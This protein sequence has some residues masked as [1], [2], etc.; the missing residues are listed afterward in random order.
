MTTVQ[1]FAFNASIAAELRDRLVAVDDQGRSIVFEAPSKFPPSEHQQAIF[2][3]IATQT[4]SLIARARA[5]SG[6]TTTILMGL[7]FIPGIRGARDVSAK[8]FHAVGLGAILKKLGLPGDQVKADGGK[9]RRIAK[10]NLIE[11]DYDMYADF[12]V[13]LVALAKG[14]GIGPLVPDEMGAWYEL[15]SHH[16]LF[17]DDDE[18]TEERGIEIARKLL[19]R[20]N[21]H[22]LTG[23]IDF[24]DMLYLPLLWRL[25]L[26][27]NDWVIVDEA[28]DTSPVRRAIAKLALKPGGRLIAVG[29]DKQA[30]YGF[31]GASHDAMDLIKREFRCAELPLTVS[32]RCPRSVA[33]RV[34]PLVP[35]FSVP[36]T[37]IQGEDVQMTLSEAIKVLGP[38]DAI[39]C[40]Q[41][42]PL[43]G[44][45]FALIA[46]GTGCHVL[47]KE[48]GQ[49]LVGLIKRQKARGIENL[50]EKLD[51]FGAREIAK[52]I[53][54]GE[55]GKAEA[56]SDRIACIKTVIDS[57]PEN[58]R[59][60]PA[61][62]LKIEG[63]FSDSNGV[64][65]LA[66]I[67]KV[68][69]KEYRRVAILRPD[70]MPSKWAR[71]DHQYQ[72]EL[73]LQYVAWTRTL[74][75]LIELTTDKFVEEKKPEVVRWDA[76]LAREAEDKDALDG[77]VEEFER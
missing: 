21:A 71:Q 69:G 16:D 51:A 28:Q 62:I 3:W 76:T 27:Q 54:R 32:Y 58:G 19:A 42:A 66:T 40:R 13:K 70:L 17:L 67:H 5:G 23:G 14:A 72:Q 56:V 20:S 10:A 8:T 6:K 61:L 15:V 47:G 18:A 7:K 11:A 63:L 68:K 36:E 12:S 49:G 4:G 33:L 74:E 77:V 37:A 9:V 2:D 53:A 46:R 50:V 64:L 26:W 35:D 30:I 44:L 73:N 34:H 41:T 52:H 43:V 31:T 25:R 38:S 29:D 60:I 24:D 1:M 65:S 45:A 75:M 48:I 57:L 59:T 22:A 55:E 39:L